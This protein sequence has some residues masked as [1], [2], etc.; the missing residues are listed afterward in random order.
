[1]DTEAMAEA[2]RA[3]WSRIAA[4]PA[5]DLQYVAWGWGERAA[6]ALVGVAP[7]DVDITSPG[8]LGSTPLLDIPPRAA[9][10]YLGTYLLSLLGGL[11]LQERTGLFYDVLTRSHVLA[12]LTQEEFWETVIRPWL[13]TDCKRALVAL[14]DYLS[15][16]RDLLALEQEE[17]DRIAH[18]A[19]AS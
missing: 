8:F 14:A 12:C 7:V 1:M 5:D 15:S 13:P 16:R 2:V 3:A 10:A 6:E 17:T 11:T 18:L 9:A 19:A 4:P